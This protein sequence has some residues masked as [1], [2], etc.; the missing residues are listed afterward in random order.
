[1][2]IVHRHFKLRGLRHAVAVDQVNRN[3]IRPTFARLKF[4]VLRILNRAVANAN[5][6]DF[7][8]TSQGIN[9]FDIFV[10]AF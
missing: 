1:L 2:N 7:M 4:N 8:L 5:I 3:I 10:I 6:C 9:G